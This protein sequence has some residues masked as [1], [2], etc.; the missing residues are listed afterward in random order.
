MVMT[1]LRK[2]GRVSHH[3]F[4]FVDQFLLQECV[5]QQIEKDEYRIK[6]VQSSNLTQNR[7]ALYL[8]LWQAELKRLHKILK[9]L[10]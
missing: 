5:R 3:I 6:M 8:E 1:L 7:K 4:D 9:D 10:E 2:N